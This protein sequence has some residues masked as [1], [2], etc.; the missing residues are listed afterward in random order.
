MY[1]INLKSNKCPKCAKVFAHFVNKMIRCQ[2]GFT[3]SETKFKIILEK[4]NRRQP[5]N[6]EEDNQEALNNF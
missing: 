5:I 4:L 6:T 3:I 2:C 1:W